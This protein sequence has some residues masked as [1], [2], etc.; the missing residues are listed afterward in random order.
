VKG[1][2]RVH[3]GDLRGLATLHEES[4]VRRAVVVSLEREP[5]R[6]DG[7]IDVLPWQVFVER[8]WRGDL[9]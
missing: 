6:V 9:V 3:E 7:A 2:R 8:L 5:R 1:T 4:R